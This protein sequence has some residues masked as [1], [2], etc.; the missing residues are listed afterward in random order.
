MHWQVVSRNMSDFH[1]ALRR[2]IQRSLPMWRTNAQCLY[3]CSGLLTPLQQVGALAIHQQAEWLGWTGGAGWLSRH[4]WDAWLTSG[5]HDILA[6]ELLPLLSEIISF[7]NDFLER[8][9]DGKRHAIPSIS[10]ENQPKG[11]PSRWTIDATMEI[12]IC[13]EVILHAQACCAALEK[14]FPSE[15]TALLEVLPHYRFNEHGELAEW[16][17]PDHQDQHEHRHLSHIYPLFP[18]DEASIGSRELR[19]GIQ[20]AVAA[21]LATGQRSQ[22]GWSL[23]HLAHIHARLGDGDQ[24]EH[25][26]ERLI[27]TC[28]QNNLLSVHDDWRGQGL[29]MGSGRRERGIL[30]LDA[31]FGTTS[32]IQEFLIQSEM[33]SLALLPALPTAWRNGSANGLTTRCGLEV[34]LSWDDGHGQASMRALRDTS[35]TVCCSC[36]VSDNARQITLLSGEEYQLEWTY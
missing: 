30:Q 34:N 35:F 10:V 18:G 20:K 1:K 16:I 29:T 24:A 11:W 2:L 5:D 33:N 7:Y 15:W 23:V 6:D 28:V 12:A 27:R 21:R 9:E 32:T 13:R 8:G 14:N 31:L 22:T 3:G 25:C 4:V 17:H 36:P 19:E 26:L